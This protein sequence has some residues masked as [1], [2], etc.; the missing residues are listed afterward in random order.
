MYLMCS[1]VSSS[2]KVDSIKR[3]SDF[4]II[5]LPY[6]GCEFFK[7]FSGNN[8]VGDKMFFDW[9]QAFIDAPISVPEDNISSQLNINWDKYTEWSLVTITQNYVRLILK[10]LQEGNSGILIHCISGWDRTPL[11]I[12]LIRM[13]LWADGLIHQS[14][15]AKQML[16]L[17]LAYDW[18]LFGH[19]LTDRIAKGEEILLFCFYMVKYIS[20]DD[21]NISSL[22]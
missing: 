17:T 15:D 3:Y 1:S 19:Q 8:Y 9:A 4:Q 7:D 16:Y 21:F 2:E 6:P 13:S 5:G 14:L 11:F 12:S 18:Y 20:E 10:Y 22:W